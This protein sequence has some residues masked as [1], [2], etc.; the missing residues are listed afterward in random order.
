MFYI[1][2]LDADLAEENCE[3]YNEGRCMN[4]TEKHFCHF[5]RNDAALDHGINYVRKERWYEKYYK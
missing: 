5:R 4:E 2:E 3:Y 1:C